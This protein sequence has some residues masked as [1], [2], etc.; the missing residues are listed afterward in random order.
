MEDIYE[1]RAK[2]FKAFC[3]ER[4]QKI[5][6]L[7]QKGELDPLKATTY[8]SGEVMKFLLER[9]CRKFL[10]GIGGSATVDGG[11]GMLQSLGARFFDSNGAELA[12]GIG[13]GDLNRIAKAD[14]SALDSRIFSSCIQVACDVTNPLLGPDGAAAVFAPQKGATPE[15][16]KILESN[17]KHWSDLCGGSPESPGNGAAGGVGF[18]LRQVLKA[19]ITSGAEVV[20]RNSGAAEALRN[21][22]LLITGE[23]CSDEQTVCGKLPAVIAETAAGYGVPAVLC[24]GA[25]KGNYAALEKVFCGVFSISNGA[26]SLDEAIKNTFQNLRLTGA[27]LA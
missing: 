8:G 26:I 12:P 11:A 10:L 2:V 27:N 15:M 17:L 7:L 13:G 19:E 1:Q 25:V 21:A 23:G 22:D 16:V 5:L 20:I 18:M 3:D 6:E 14:L 9:G 4:R 24:S